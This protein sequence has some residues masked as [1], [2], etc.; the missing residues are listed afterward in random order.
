MKKTITALALAAALTLT[1]CTAQPQQQIAEPAESASAVSSAP[2]AAT[3]PTASS[4]P[5]VEPTEYAFATGMTFGKVTTTGKPG[6]EL[7]AFLSAA[8]ETVG[9]EYPAGFEYWTVKIDNRDGFE[10]AFP[11]E[12]RVYDEAGNEYL[13]IRGIDLVEAAQEEMPD[14]PENA[15]G[16][17]PEWKEHERL[18]G[19]YESAFEAENYSANPG[20]VKEFTVVTGD[21]LPDD[22]ARITIDLGGLTGE[23]DVITLEDAQSQGYPLDF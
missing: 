22:I 14:A 15:T 3:T 13:F 6:K 7:D 2:A 1:A 11:N 9:E 4:E 16:D 20:A 10:V 18:F 19:L 17:S 21:D 5:V 8:A 12:L 23:A